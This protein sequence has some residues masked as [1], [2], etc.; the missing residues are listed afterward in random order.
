MKKLASCIVVLVSFGI[1]TAS[2][3]NHLTT[4]VVQAFGCSLNDGRTM[5]DA[6]S[7]LGELA[8]NAAANENPDPRFGLF[9]W[10][11]LRGGTDFDFVFGALN[12]DVKT[13]AAGIEAFEASPEGQALRDRFDATADCVSG[14]FESEQIAD[15]TIGMTGGDATLD[16]IVETF[17]C[18]INDGS[19]MADVDAAVKYWQAQV[20]KIESQALDAY[21]AYVWKPIRGGTGADLI[22][23]GNAASMEAW[24][25]G[26]ADYNGSAAGQAADAR[27][28]KHSTCTSNLYQGYWLVAPK[29]F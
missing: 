24:A 15:G 13:A 8:Q 28:F 2:A 10:R 14:I 18:Q 12:V 1:S 4:G 7:V 19:D 25:A 27:F 5:A 29:E 22:W 23:V 3:D 26:L 16:A 11:P 20:A 6:R 21:E 17:S 9:A